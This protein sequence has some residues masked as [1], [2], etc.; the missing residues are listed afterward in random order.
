MTIA[1]DFYEDGAGVLAGDISIPQQGVRMLAL[2]SCERR[3]DEVG[4]ELPRQPGDPVFR[5][6]ISADGQSIAGSLTQGGLSFPFRLTRAA[7]AL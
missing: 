2:A 5:G 7:P 4:F 6:T 3:G 1:L